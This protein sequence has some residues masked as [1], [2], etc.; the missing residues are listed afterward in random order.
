MLHHQN[1]T[2]FTIFQLNGRYVDFCY[3]GVFLPDFGQ[4]VSSL[5]TTE[6]F[7]GVSFPLYM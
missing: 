5:G 3:F 6:E 7:L 4:F 2:D 1:L